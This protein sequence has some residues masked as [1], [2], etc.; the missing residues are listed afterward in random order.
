MVNT[1]ILKDVDDD[2]LKVYS[3]AIPMGRSGEPSE[4]ANVAFFLASDEASYVTGQTYI[5]HGGKDTI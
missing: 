2:M 3:E 4:L 1:G 5:V